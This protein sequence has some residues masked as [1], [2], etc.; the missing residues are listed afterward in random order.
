M[1]F[2]KKSFNRFRHTKTHL[3]IVNNWIIY[4]ENTDIHPLHYTVMSNK[5]NMASEE[6]MACGAVLSLFTTQYLTSLE[7]VDSKI[8]ITLSF[9]QSQLGIFRRRIWSEFSCLLLLF[10]KND[11]Q[12]TTYMHTSNYFSVSNPVYT[13]IARDRLIYFIPASHGDISPTVII[14]DN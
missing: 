14:A 3:L 8:R 5:T 6:D 9:L 11:I 13:I 4:A 10:V 1:I 12:H 2:R 7:T